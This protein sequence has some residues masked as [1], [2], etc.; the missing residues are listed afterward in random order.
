MSTEQNQ[1]NKQHKTPSLLSNNTAVH[2]Q[3][4]AM[5]FSVTSRLSFLLAARPGHTLKEGDNH[6]GRTK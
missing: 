3:P 6:A 5:S 4:A 1:A 2:T